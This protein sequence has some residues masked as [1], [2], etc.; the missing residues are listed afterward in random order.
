M[1]KEEIKD[2][3]KFLHE[4]NIFL[5]FTQNYRNNRL[6]INPPNLGGLPR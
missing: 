5:M 6:T 1:T 2:F 3:K 4:K